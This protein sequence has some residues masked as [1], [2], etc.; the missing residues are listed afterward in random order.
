MAVVVECRRPFDFPDVAYAEH[1][2]QFRNAAL[3]PR[4][5]LDDL[6][7][8][9]H[10]YVRLR[11]HDA[12]DDTGTGVVLPAVPFEPAGEHVPGDHPPVALRT[13]LTEK[14]RDGLEPG[15]L[16]A[17]TAVERPQRELQVGRGYDDNR[18][19][20]ICYLAPSV[21]DAVGVSPDEPVELCNPVDGGRSVLHTATLSEEDVNEG[22]VR[23][24][25]HIQEALDVGFGERVSVRSPSSHEPVEPSIRERLL[26]WLIDYREVH[27]R[28]ELGLDR[29]EYR[30]VVRMQEDTMQFLG[31]DPGDRIVMT[32]NGKRLSTQCLLPPEGVS[33]PDASLLVAST[34]RDPVDV[35]LY[36]TVTVRRDMGHI[37]KQQVAVST[38]GILGV[39]F[40]VFQAANAATLDDMLVAEFGP[41]GTI[42]VLAAVAALA[43]VLVIW[44]LL[45]P[46]RQKC[47]RPS[48]EVR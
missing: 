10:E 26:G 14:L 30:N 6:D 9:P 27:L 16:L 37:L 20:G 17:V 7:V 11:L 48:T 23:F 29:D 46:E 13:N 40:G 33:V 28:V 43:S 38:L 44:L 47:S 31:I 22:M 3:L 2:D 34:D 36:D 12:V 41:F 32:W 25:G 5:V 19:A 4:S 45:F 8:A 24:D 39:V 35:S 18:G 1:D 15:T 21:R 42:V